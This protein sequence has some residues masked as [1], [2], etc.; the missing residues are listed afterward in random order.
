MKVE[1][2]VRVKL[3]FT[4][5]REHS[6]DSNMSS[7][8]AKKAQAESPS[9]YSSFAPSKLLTRSRFIL[10]AMLVLAV[11]LHA[12]ALRLAAR[13]LVVDE[14]FASVDAVVVVS[15]DRSIDEAVRLV[16][17]GRARDVLL[18][19]PCPT[20]LVRYGVLA[21]QAEQRRSQL[22]AR[23][24]AE[25]AVVVLDG[26]ANGNWESVRRL[27]RWLN[28]HPERRVLIL[29]DRFHG[30]YQHHIVGA[31]IDEA[32]A[33][34]VSYCGLQDRRF[35]ES[36]W[37]QSR[38]GIKEFIASAM[39]LAHVLVCGESP[40]TVEWWDP[41]EYERQLVSLAQGS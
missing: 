5:E 7:P 16:R 6:A 22:I 35:D 14:N 41:D 34:R 18:I 36:N 23:G 20:R 12:P 17:E 30:R 9:S 21:P 25:S 39:D 13:L 24:V 8:T 19:E 38:S 37:W 15:G 1:S 40:P 26:E 2:G 10:A 27:G 3:P 31:V 11:T 29:R 32:A 4:V 28:E 33:R